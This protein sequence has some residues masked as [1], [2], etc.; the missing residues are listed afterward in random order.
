MF[1]FEIVIAL[2]LIGAVLSLW[3]ARLG[4]PYPA[5]L[6]FTGAALALIPGVPEVSLDPQLALALFVAPTLLDAAYDASPRDLR[7]NLIPVISL[8]TG[9]VGLTIA[10]V[11]VITR[12]FVPMSVGRLRSRSAPLW[13]RRT[14]P[15]P[16]RCCGELLRHT[17]SRSS[18]KA[19]ACSMTPAHCSSTVLRP[20]PP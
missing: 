15:R 16:L 9:A 17:A 11:A 3:A 1:I 2:L 20:L 6:A 13:L 19:R 10:A 4:V 7:D 14:L 12:L 8:A 18:W 5:L